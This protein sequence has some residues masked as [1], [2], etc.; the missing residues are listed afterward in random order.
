MFSHNTTFGR[1][2]EDEDKFVV[3]SELYA[4]LLYSLNLLA[5]YC[6][7]I[8][9]LISELLILPSWRTGQ[10]TLGPNLP[11][12]SI[13][14]CSK[15]IL[16]CVFTLLPQ[17]LILLILE[18][19][20]DLRAFRWL[21]TLLESLQIVSTLPQQPTNYATNRQGGVFLRLLSL[22]AF[23]SLWLILTLLFTG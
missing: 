5:P 23:P 19:L 11:K 7:Q 10:S 14:T 4:I 9:E 13:S 15:A 3:R 6:M 12:L 18:L 8:H 21:I 17:L 2:S 16:C 1:N 22:K 20:I